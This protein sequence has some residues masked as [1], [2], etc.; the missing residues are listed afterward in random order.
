MERE[1]WKEVKELFRFDSCCNIINKIDV[2]NSKH[3]YY[4]SNLGRFKRDDNILNNKPDSTGSVIYSLNGYRFKLHQIVLQT[5]KPEGIKD[6]YSVDHINRFNRWDNSLS[7]LRWADKRTQVYNRDNSEH[8]YKKVK[9]LNNGI[10]YISC[11]H[12]EKSLGLA[13]NTVSKMA[14]EHIALNGYKFEYI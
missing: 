10:I 6:G 3:K 9:C 7:N 1:E 5:F 13:H 12:A 11:Q 2:T 14:R 8:Q 4:V